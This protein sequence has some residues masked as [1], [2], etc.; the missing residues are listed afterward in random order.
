MI[1]SIASQIKK[2]AGDIDLKKWW[3]KLGKGQIFLSDHEYVNDFCKLASPLQVKKLTIEIE[4]VGKNALS[5]KTRIIADG[6]QLGLISHLSIDADVNKPYVDIKMI[7]STTKS[8]EGE[9]VIPSNQIP[10]KGEVPAKILR[11]MMGHAVTLPN[12]SPG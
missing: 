12:L 1:Q 4:G 2:F 5:A 9:K 10:H 6:K 11:A 7:R 8:K 3:D